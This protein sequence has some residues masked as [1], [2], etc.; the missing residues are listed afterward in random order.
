MIDWNVWINENQRHYII[1]W[2]SDPYIVQETTIMK[3]VKPRQIIVS[4][5]FICDVV[6]NNLVPNNIDRYTP[7]D[8]DNGYVMIRLK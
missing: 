5:E 8:K 6:F 1:K 2:L 4:G 7:M 3:G